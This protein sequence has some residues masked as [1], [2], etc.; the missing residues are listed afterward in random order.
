MKMER[1]AEQGHPVMSGRSHCV[2][3]ATAT[4]TAMRRKIAVWGGAESRL[5]RAFTM[6]EVM[7]AVALFS[8]IVAAIYSSWSAI[9]RG[10]KAG[11]VAAADAQRT[12]IALRAVREALSSAQLYTHP[13]ALQHYAFIMDRSGDFADMSFVSRLSDSFPGSGL[14]GD[15]II[16]RVWFRVERGDNGKNQL[17]LRQMPLLEPPDAA[18]KPYT[19]VLAPSVRMFAIEFLDSKYRWV[20]EW[21][22]TNQLPR[23]ARVTLSFGEGTGPLKEEDVSI[24]TIYFSSMAI[25]P[26]LQMPRLG[27]Q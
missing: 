19:I 20:E 9:L 17:V 11:L 5:A 4:A 16:R 10:S 14:F 12:R 7:V 25:P 21:P 24:E 22:Y 2:R 6:I 15:Q 27:G 3:P 26:A 18:T 1:N 8:M 23:M 13:Q